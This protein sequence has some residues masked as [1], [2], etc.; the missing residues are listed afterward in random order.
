MVLPNADGTI[1]QVLQTNG[2]G[3]L[4]WADLGIS[5]V[6]DDTSP[7]LGGNLDVN[8][9]DIVSTSNGDIELSPN[10]T[11]KVIFKGNATS[12]SGRFVLNCE[13][14]SHGITI[15][16]PPHSASA[17][18]TLTLPNDDGDNNQVLQTNGS[19]VLSWATVSSGSTTTINNNSDNRIITGSSSSDTLEAEANLTYDG[20]NFD[21]TCDDTNVN[22]NLNV[23]GQVV[24][25]GSDG[26]LQFT[27]AGENSIKIPDNQSSALIIE[28][29]N[30]AYITFDTSNGSEA[31]TV[32]KATTF[33]G[34]VEVTGDLT[35]SNGDGALRFTNATELNKNTR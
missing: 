28:E 2:G 20:I 27:N 17:N 16:G 14:N 8:G 35:L 11:G 19:G 4:T 6:V 22:S 12:G 33:S 29:A 34:N 15:Q 9:K 5:N 25:T 31:I 13:N 1:N 21:I 32:A 24:L 10:G 18:Y 7:Q 26:A 3:D 23:N 30:N